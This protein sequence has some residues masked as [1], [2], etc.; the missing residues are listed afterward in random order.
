M[1]I[2]KI[3]AFSFDELSDSSKSRAVANFLADEDYPF[4]Y[5]CEKAIRAF[6][7]Y[8]GAGK[9]EY[10][11]GTHSHSY[12]TA[13]VDNENF[14]G[15][16]LAHYEDA[17]KLA[18][19]GYCEEIYMFEQ[20]HAEWERTGSALKAF[21]FALDQGC[22]SIVKDME[23]FQSEEYASE[24]LTDMEYLFDEDGERLKTNIFVDAEVL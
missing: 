3:A 13:K 10:S 2:K 5:D 9:L 22:R 15:L 12:I 21:Q 1:Q 14:R 4:W 7:D 18:K 16:K 20:F 23:Y 17:E 24:Y 19:T 6:C 11:I 8:F